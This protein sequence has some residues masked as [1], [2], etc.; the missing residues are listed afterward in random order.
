M[1]DAVRVSILQRITNVGGDGEGVLRRQLALA[2]DHLGHIGAVDE[3]H[4]DVELAV[5]RFAEVVH[6]DDGRVVHLGHRARLVLEACDKL[7]VVVCG[8]G[9]QELDGD[10]TVERFL[11]ALVNCTHATFA[12]DVQDFIG[13]QQRLQMLR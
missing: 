2:L 3:F 4:D 1:H 9:W 5:G 10:E 6:M 12:D 11:A 7:H 8:L 13:G